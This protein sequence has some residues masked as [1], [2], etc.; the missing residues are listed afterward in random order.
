M[1]RNGEGDFPCGAPVRVWLLSLPAPCSIPAHSWGSATP[2][3][4]QKWN[5]GVSAGT[6]LHLTRPWEQNVSARSFCN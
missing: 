5:S 6:F 3:G 4:L 1:R 2:N